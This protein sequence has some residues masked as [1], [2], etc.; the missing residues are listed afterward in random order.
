MRKVYVNITVRAVIEMDEGIEVS[1]V[2]QEMDYGF[3]C[4]TGG[5]DIVDTE[6]VGHKVTD[7]K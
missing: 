4:N 7:S 3:N 2:I 1:E 5:A 6:I